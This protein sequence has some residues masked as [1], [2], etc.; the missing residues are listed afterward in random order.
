MGSNS[1]DDYW[2]DGGGSDG[3]LRCAIESFCDIP[4]AGVAIEDTYADICGVEQTSSKKRCRDD[5]CTG[6]KSKAC[7]EKMRRDKL[8]DRFLELSAAIDPCRPPKSDKASI[9]SDAAHV[10]QQ[11]KAEAQEI[12]DSNEKLQDTIKDLKMEKNELRDEKLKLKADK[13][14]LEQQIKAMNMPPA[15]FMPPL[16]FHPAATPA[17]FAPHIQAPSNKAAHFPTY[18]GMAMWQWLP[19]AV[20]DTTQDTNLWPP[21]A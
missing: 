7:R 13:E 5:S 3:E 10:L 2:V 12:K 8:N 15:G 11:L 18:P 17:A 20:V 14:R 9:L 6:S 21:N 4:T 16:A 1:I 19:P